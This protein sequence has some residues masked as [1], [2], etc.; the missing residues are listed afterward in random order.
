M[1][2]SEVKELLHQ[3]VDDELEPT[4]A[5]QVRLALADCPDCQHEL[6]ELEAVS[7]LAR[8]AFLAPIEGVD[9]SRVFDGVMAR[10]A[11]APEAAPAQIGEAAQAASDGVKVQREVIEERPGLLERFGQWLGELFRLE[12]PLAAAASFA[13]LAAIV[14]GLWFAMG[15]GATPAAAPGGDGGSM[16]ATGS[17][18]GTTPAPQPD[19]RRRRSME[20]EQSVIAGAVQVESFEVAEGRIE[21]EDS[22]GD[23]GAV[24]V[25]HLDEEPSAAPDGQGL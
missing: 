12:H 19:Q 24:V 23:E 16:V 13:A 8:E 10:L 4:R 14:G 9:L 2:C 20:A 1:N 6:A 5:E 15:D 21:I 7:A 11:Q 3:L 18:K 17:D 25:W 22:A